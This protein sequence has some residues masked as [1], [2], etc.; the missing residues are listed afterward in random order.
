MNDAIAL[1]LWEDQTR[2]CSGWMSRHRLVLPNQ[3]PYASLPRLSCVGNT[4][5]ILKCL[6][7]AVESTAS[8]IGGT[9]AIIVVVAGITI[10]VVIIITSRRSDG[11]S[12]VCVVFWARELYLSLLPLR[13][14]PRIGPSKRALTCESFVT[15]SPPRMLLISPPLYALIIRVHLTNEP[16]IDSFMNPLR[17]GPALSLNLGPRLYP[18][19]PI[20][21]GTALWRSR[22]P[23]QRKIGRVCEEAFTVAQ[24]VAVLE[25]EFEDVVLYCDLCQALAAAC[26]VGAVEMWQL[27]KYR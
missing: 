2:Y 23:Q 19:R 6:V 16:P 15:S 12:I 26:E 13:H 18:P 5:C 20:Y 7:A 8:T 27:V 21:C 14:L 1:E 17:V 25:F 3:P 4:T 22:R 24:P 9:S 11:R 10:V